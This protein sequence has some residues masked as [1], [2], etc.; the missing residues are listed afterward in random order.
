MYNNDEF[1]KIIK[2]RLSE[3]RFQH[4]LN[5]ADS[6]K[7]LAIKFGSDEEKAYTAAILHDIMK[8]ETIDIQREYMARNG[9]SITELEFPNPLVFHQ[10]SGAAYC[11]LELGVDDEDILSAIRFHTTG[12]RNMSLLEKV[13]YTADFISADRCYPDIDIMRK[14]AEI[15][16]DE[17]MLYS[18]KYTITDLAKKEKPIH[19]DAIECYNDILENF[20]EKDLDI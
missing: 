3:K 20:K 16:L 6:A 15:S 8:E 18:L 2:E 13:V 9:E 12:R 4:S 17:A 10:M 11:R 19:P 14:K 7:R 1:I 5:V